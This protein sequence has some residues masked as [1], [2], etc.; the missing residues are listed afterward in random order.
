[1]VQD[2]VVGEE[3]ANVLK[4]VV[5]TVK[6]VLLRF[7]CRFGEHRVQFL[8][9]FFGIQSTGSIAFSEGGRGVFLW[10]LVKSRGK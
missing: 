6:Q 4:A 9:G 5:D 7:V 10:A 8:G 2:A 1:M 3:L